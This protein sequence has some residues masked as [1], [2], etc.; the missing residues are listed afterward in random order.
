MNAPAAEQSETDNSM[1]DVAGSVST[2]EGVVRHTSAVDRI[3]EHALP[4]YS[5]RS[6]H[7]LSANIFA[8]FLDS[9]EMEHW[10]IDEINDAL[11]T[12]AADTDA[13]IEMWSDSWRFMGDVMNCVMDQY[14]ETMPE[15]DRERLLERLQSDRAELRQLSD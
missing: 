15:D 14:I 11:T 3:H 8:A 7:H 9:I 13:F 2:P 4:A 12:S 10:T 5:S 1:G 6:R